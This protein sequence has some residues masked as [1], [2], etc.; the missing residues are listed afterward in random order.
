MDRRA[1][2]KTGKAEAKR[3][4]VRKSPKN[5]VGKVND[6]ATRLTEALGQLQTR[7]REL[8]EA[9]EQQTATAEILSVISSSPS[10]VQP[11][12]ERVVERALRLLGGLTAAVVLVRDGVCHLGAFTALDESADAAMRNVYPR[13]LSEVPLTERSE[14]RRVGKEWSSRGGA[15]A[16]K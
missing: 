3:P 5:S 10:D 14:E 8:A 16:T 6:L 13:S 11:V 2:P 15:E 4:P 7:D 1:Q 9:L 12:F